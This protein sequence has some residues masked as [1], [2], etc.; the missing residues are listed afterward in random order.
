[1]RRQPPLKRELVLKLMVARGEGDWGETVKEAKGLRNRNQ[2]QNS[3][4][5]IKNGLA[6][7]VN[8]VIT[9]DSA[10]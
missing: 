3:H 8:N 9:M 10:R 7:I 4:G 6:N 5:D 1:M 2:S